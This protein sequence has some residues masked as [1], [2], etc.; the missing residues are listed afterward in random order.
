MKYLAIIIALLCTP[1]Y[2]DGIPP[3]A[4]EGISECNFYAGC[5]KVRVA[6]DPDT[7]VYVGRVLSSYREV[8]YSGWHF[9]EYPIDG[10]T[11]YLWT[12]DEGLYWGDLAKISANSMSFVYPDSSCQPTMGT[13][14]NQVEPDDFG[15]SYIFRVD[16]LTKDYVFYQLDLNTASPATNVYYTSN[17]LGACTQVTNPGWAVFYTVTDTLVYDTYPYS[18]YYFTAYISEVVIADDSEPPTQSL[19]DL[20]QS[21][22]DLGDSL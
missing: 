21:P 7:G 8:R 3:W 13:F 1:V 14:T 16:P 9:L 17:G 10:E 11:A 22:I 2:S 12:L 20:I 4:G 5:D 19:D 18:K 6:Y 15:S